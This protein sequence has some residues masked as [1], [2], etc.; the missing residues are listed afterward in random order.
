M[1]SESISDKTLLRTTLLAERKAINIALRQQWDAAINSQLLSWWE[2]HP[3]ARLGV[4]W[5][6]RN[7][8][9]LHVLYEELTTRGVQLGLPVVIDR[10]APL[11]F[12]AW[13]PGDPLVKDAMG[14]LVPSHQKRDMQPEA[15]L[16]PCVGFNAS[17][18]RL[19]YGGGFYD[20]TLAM[21]PHPFAIGVGYQCALASFH[22]DPHDIELDMIVTETGCIT[23]AT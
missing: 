15:L 4:Y 5:P 3:V 22:G 16:I 1:S 7:E 9:D 8:P 10:D 19:G 14:I 18:V 11:Q 2:Q 21:H 6:I 17:R 13:T 20:R 12:A 23:S